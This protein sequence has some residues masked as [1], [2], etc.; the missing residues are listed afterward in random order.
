MM[1]EV[2]KAGSAGR[3]GYIRTGTDVAILALFSSAVEKKKKKIFFFFFW[4]ALLSSFFFLLLLFFLLFNRYHRVCN[5][6]NKKKGNSNLMKELFMCNGTYIH[7]S[8]PKVFY[9]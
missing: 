6:S 3:R 8:D 7:I 2:W 9:L 5:L 4:V 1:K